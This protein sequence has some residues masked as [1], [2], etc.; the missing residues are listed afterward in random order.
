[1]DDKAFMNVWPEWQ[2]KKKIGQGSYG[3]VYEPR[4]SEERS[5]E[6]RGSGQRCDEAGYLSVFGGC[7]M[8]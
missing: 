2:L 6:A 8:N 7:K 5:D 3:A 1:M 4:P